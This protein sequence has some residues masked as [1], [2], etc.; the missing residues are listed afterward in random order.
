MLP[1]R[2][3]LIS[4]LALVQQQELR[5]PLPTSKES[6]LVLNASLDSLLE[7]VKEL[8]PG[9]PLVRLDYFV[10]IFGVPPKRA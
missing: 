1:F 2:H 3:S 8:D 4:Y 10:H 5:L 9:R 6:N 7:L